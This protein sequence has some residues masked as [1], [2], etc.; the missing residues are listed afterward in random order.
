MRSAPSIGR[1]GRAQGSLMVG[2]SC[3]ARWRRAA[4][5]TSLV[6]IAMTQGGAPERIPVTDPFRSAGNLPKPEP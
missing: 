3:S 2:P 1:S 4:H 5:R 6:P